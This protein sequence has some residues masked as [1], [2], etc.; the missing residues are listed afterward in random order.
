MSQIRATLAS[1]IGIEN[2]GNIGEDDRILG[3]V[4]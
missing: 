2:N 3:H 1:Q 4:S